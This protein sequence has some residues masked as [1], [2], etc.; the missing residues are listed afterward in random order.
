MNRPTYFFVFMTA[1]STVLSAADSGP[2]AAM[3]REQFL[4]AHGP[5]LAS[6][7]QVKAAD[8]LSGRSASE[9]IT[10]AL[11]SRASENEAISVVLDGRDWVVTEA[12]VLPSN[13]ELIIDGCR[14]KLADGV[15]D[16]IV[17]LARLRPDP[18]NPNGPCLGREP[19]HDIRLIGRNGAAIEGAEHPFVGVNPK[20]GVKEPWLGDFFGWRIFFNL[21]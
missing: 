13:T 5:R 3:S 20:T 17:R 19:A 15:F 18:A 10:A 4:A 8:F 2:L 1:L 7:R 14:L 6:P 9:A 21:I 16:N 12:V 11:A